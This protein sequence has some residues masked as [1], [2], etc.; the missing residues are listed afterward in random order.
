MTRRA[1]IRTL[2]RAYQNLPGR[3]NSGFNDDLRFLQAKDLD[4]SVRLGALLTFDG[5]LVTAAVNPIVDSPGAPLSLDAA[6]Q[7]IEMLVVVIGLVLLFASSWLVVR[8]LMIG[9]EPPVAGS[10]SD[11]STLSE[12]LLAAY[13]RSIEG[14]LRLS[15]V[16]SKL[17]LAGSAV[18]AAVWAWILIDKAAGATAP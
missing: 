2:L 8:G 12:R 18:T 5:I 4:V 14:Q 15:R 17:T 9:E 6:R 16:A 3:E 7:P 11:A 13:C 10:E 1:S